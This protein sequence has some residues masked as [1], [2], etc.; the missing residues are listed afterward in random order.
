VSSAYRRPINLGS[1]YSADRIQN[2]IRFKR[3]YGHKSIEKHYFKSLNLA[4][5][6]GHEQDA[7]I[8]IVNH[9]TYFPQAKF[10]LNK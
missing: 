4:P 2:L 3:L 9:I 1:F 6:I 7:G 5:W 10:H 8:K